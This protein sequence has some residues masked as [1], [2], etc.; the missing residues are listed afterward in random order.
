MIGPGP[1]KISNVHVSF[2]KDVRVQKVRKSN[3]SG[4]AD[5][6]AKPAV[7]WLTWGIILK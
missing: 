6:G 7:N 3:H 5:P 4:I 2:G 1:Q